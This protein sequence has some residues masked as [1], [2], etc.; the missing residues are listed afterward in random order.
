MAACER[1]A[2]VTA[3][4]AQAPAGTCRVSPSTCVPPG[5]PSTSAM[6]SQ[7]RRFSLARPLAFELDSVEV[8]E[9]TELERAEG[10]SGCNRGHRSWRFFLESLKINSCCQVYR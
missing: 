6:S 9:V 10:F 4:G 7:G 3:A 5:A 1:W 2:R 8:L